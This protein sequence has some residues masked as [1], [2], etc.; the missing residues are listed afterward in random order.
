MNNRNAT[1]D[2]LQATETSN[3]ISEEEDQHDDDELDDDE[4]DFY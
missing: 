4:D 3:D 1:P 2:E